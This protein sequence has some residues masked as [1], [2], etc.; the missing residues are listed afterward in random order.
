[1]AHTQA[2]IAP[3]VG[4][5]MPVVMPPISN[6]GVMIG[7]TAWKLKNLSAANRPIKP[8]NTVICGGNPSFVMSAH[9]A[10]GHPMT[11]AV[12]ASA[13]MTRGHSNLISAPQPFLWAK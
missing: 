13:L 9:M 1:M 2:A 10:S 11:T 8:A 6:T 12:S 7:N 5:K 3:S 4:V